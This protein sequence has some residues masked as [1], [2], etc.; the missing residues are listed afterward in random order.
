MNLIFSALNFNPLNSNLLTTMLIKLIIYLLF[1]SFLAASGILFAIYFLHFQV[2]LLIVIIFCSLFLI[3]GI[4]Y[5]LIFAIS[6]NISVKCEDNKYHVS[7]VKTTL[8]FPKMLKKNLISYSHLTTA[9][10]DFY[11][12][13]SIDQLG[14]DFS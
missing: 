3:G 14:K 8:L 9:L 6:N 10:Y 2:V 4:P 13:K 11:V 7:D 5:T 12:N 1:F